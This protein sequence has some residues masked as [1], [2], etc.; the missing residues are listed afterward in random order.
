MATSRTFAFNPG[1]AIPGT[2]QIGNLAIGTPTNGFGSTGLQWWNG[3]DEELGYII[4]R[5]TD[6]QPTPLFSGDMTLSLIYKPVDIIL[7][8]YGRTA[9]VTNWA[10]VQSILGNTLINNNDKVVFSL[11]Y[12]ATNPATSSNA[13]IGLGTRS[14][15]Y[16][17]L[18]NG[19]PGNDDQSIGFNQIGQVWFDNNPVPSPPL[20]SWGHGDRIDVAVDQGN[21]TM[22]M[23]VGGGFWNNDSNA[24]PETNQ[25]GVSYNIGTFDHKS[26]Y[27]VLSPGS[28]G[29]NS[30]GTMALTLTP[31]APLPN[32]FQFLGS[33]VNASV[34]FWRSE[35][36]FFSPELND[37][38]FIDLVNNKFSQNF[39]TIGQCL[40]YLDSVSCWHSYPI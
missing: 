5:V 36:S 33:N 17:G 24:N 29:G 18:F 16:N 30:Y 15:N 26:I 23:R 38:Y 8:T 39:T 6:N 1:T 20:P 31:S 3:P 35:Y 27:P 14:M 19:F 40:T 4:A 28:G 37:G 13:W 21:E 9:S 22:W 7:D 2:T 32:G 11:I 10:Y 12:T 25:N 34:G